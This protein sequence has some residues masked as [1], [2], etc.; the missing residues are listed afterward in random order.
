MSSLRTG[1][2]LAHGA[3]QYVLSSDPGQVTYRTAALTNL[4]PKIFTDAQTTNATGALNFGLPTGYFS[5]IYAVQAQA[6]RD[7]ANPTL[8]AFALV[9]GYNLDVVTVQVFES[10]TTPILLGGNV[11]GIELATTAVLVQLMVIGV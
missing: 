6:I 10:K 2:R 4:N 5:V 11:E 8:A 9:R 3:A 1:S 7:T